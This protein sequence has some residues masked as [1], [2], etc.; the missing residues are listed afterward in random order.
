MRYEVKVRSSLIHHR[1]NLETSGTRLDT[2]RRGSVFSRG[3]V[4]HE[5]EGG[6]PRVSGGGG[7]E[8]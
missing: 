8:E 5:T 7:A 2:G 1:G 3:N 6:L 4:E